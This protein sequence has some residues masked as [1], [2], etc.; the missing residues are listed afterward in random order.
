MK[1]RLFQKVLDRS[2]DFNACQDDLNLARGL[3]DGTDGKT[4]P[5]DPNF[6]VYA[7]TLNIAGV[8]AVQAL[9]ILELIAFNNKL[10]D[11]QE[12]YMPSYP[13]LSP[14]TT[15]FFQAWMILDARISSGPTLGELFAHYLQ[16][17]IALSYLWK[18]LQA[19]NNSQASFYEVVG[20]GEGLLRLWD[21]PGQREISCWNSSGYPGRKGEVWYVRVLPPVLDGCD[22]SVT[23]NTP[24][25]FRREGRDTWEGF[26]RRCQSF[27]SDPSREL[28]DYL[29]HGKSLA[30][31]LEYIF[32]TYW[33]HTGNAIF[34]AGLPDIAAS[35]PHSKLGRKL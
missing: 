27:A 19:L 2:Y 35:R 22:H 14:V 24:Y 33:D 26:F 7:A 25:V 32:Q 9:D 8:F 17:E 13:P 23:L 21:I 5:G 28:R 30:Y 31:W 18:P 15:S 16:T 12:E 34:L 1:D 11:F 20:V 29:K 10:A 3:Q 4:K 6:H